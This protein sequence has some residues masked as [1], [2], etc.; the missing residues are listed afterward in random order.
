MDQVDAVKRLANARPR[1]R[2]SISRWPSARGGEICS[3]SSASISVRK[4]DLHRAGQE[5]RGARVM[6]EWSPDPRGRGGA[7]QIDVPADPR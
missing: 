1:L 6:V 4:R 3:S 5:S 2:L 7:A